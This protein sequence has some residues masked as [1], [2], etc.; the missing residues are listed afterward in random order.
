MMHFLHPFL[1][2]F[3]ILCDVPPLGSTSLEAKRVVINSGPKN[4]KDLLKKR[5]V[6]RHNS[7]DA[8]G[9]SGGRLNR[10]SAG[11]RRSRPKSIWD[12]E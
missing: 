1:E 5:R 8:Q 4:P 9:A 7:S 3:D 2:F 6:R 11:R 10:R 12:G